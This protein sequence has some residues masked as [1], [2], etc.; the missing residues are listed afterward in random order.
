[1]LPA[2]VHSCV[3][4][5]AV[6]KRPHSH[7]HSPQSLIISM[8][9]YLLSKFWFADGHQNLL[10]IC[11]QERMAYTADCSSDNATNNITWWLSAIIIWFAGIISQKK[12]VHAVPWYDL[13]LSEDDML[14]L[15]VISSRSNLLILGESV[16]HYP[17]TIWTWY[18]LVLY[19]ESLGF[20]P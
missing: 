5:A 18:Y 15:A 7:C 8:K 10:I 2:T 9:Q 1:M 4:P 16:K 20:E 3:I 12:Y 17:V 6:L 13:H 14:G 19:P 11:S